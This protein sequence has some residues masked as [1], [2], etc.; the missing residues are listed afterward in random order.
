M[1]QVDIFLE[2]AE[3]VR[4]LKRKESDYDYINKK[5][6]GSC[7]NARK[8]EDRNIELHKENQ[9]LKLTIWKYENILLS[10]GLELCRECNGAGIV[11]NKGI[12]ICET[13]NGL[14]QIAVEK[15]EQKTIERGIINHGFPQF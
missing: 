2:L 5:W 11:I 12:I 6:E 9:K 4:E 15:P 8:L 1:S 7:V 14:G 3:D 13:C 10:K